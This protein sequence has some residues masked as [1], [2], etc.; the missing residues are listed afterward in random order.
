MIGDDVW[1]GDN[2]VIV[3]PVTI[4][5]GSIVAANSVVRTDIPAF[6]MVGGIPA[7][8]I[9]RFDQQASRWERPNP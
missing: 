8:T 4:G 9:R 6:T 3:G 7:R 2:V 1:I 5:Q